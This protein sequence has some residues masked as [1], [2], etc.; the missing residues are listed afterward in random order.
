[1]RGESNSDG[2]AGKSHDRDCGC[3]GSYLVHYVIIKVMDY[4]YA[5][6]T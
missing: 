4:N 1:M 6:S 5:F 3:G 2:D